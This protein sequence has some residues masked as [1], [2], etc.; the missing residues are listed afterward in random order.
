MQYEFKS[1]FDDGFFPRLKELTD[2]PDAN[3]YTLQD[4]T[5]YLYWAEWSD[6]DLK[7]DLNDEDNAYINVLMNTSK[8]KNRFSSDELWQMPTFEFFKQF[9]EFVNIV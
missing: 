5:N 1:F 6:L 9:S 3:D 4:V 8:Y 2:M 7:F